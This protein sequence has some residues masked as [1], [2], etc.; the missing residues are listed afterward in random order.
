MFLSQTF[1]PSDIPRLVA[2]TFLEIVLSADNAIVLG[3]L[4]HSLAPE[5]RRKALSIGLLSAFVLRVLALLA[6]SILLAYPWLQLLG[7][8]YLI[9]LAI[10]HFFKTRKEQLVPAVRSFW[11]TVLLI[12]LFDLA[13]AVDSIIAGLAFITAGFPSNALIHPKLWIVYIGGILGLV[14]IR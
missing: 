1:D 6:I 9:Y 4:V 5:S 11:K 3:L 7:A 8:A 14:S 10:Q 2:L 13:F 12:E